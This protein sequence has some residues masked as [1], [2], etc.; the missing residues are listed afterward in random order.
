MIFDG[1]MTDAYHD[2]YCY[3]YAYNQ[4]GRVIMQEM[5]VAGAYSYYNK[6]GFSAS[7]RD[8]RVRAESVQQSAA[9]LHL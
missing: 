8:E 5:T 4:A 1:G 6:I 2:T 9:K 7:L 3:L